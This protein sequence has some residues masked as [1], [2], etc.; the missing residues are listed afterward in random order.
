MPGTLFIARNLNEKIPAGCWTHGGMQAQIDSQG[1][2][3]LRDEKAGLLY[4][5]PKPHILAVHSSKDHAARC[6]WA[7]PG[8]DGLVVLGVAE[9]GWEDSGCGVNS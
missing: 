4:N 3:A 2:E 5:R 9:R 6:H 1:V 8:P 7:D